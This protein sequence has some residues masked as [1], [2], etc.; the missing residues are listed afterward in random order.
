VAAAS[1]TQGFL[2]GMRGVAFYL[3]V[4]GFMTIG[5]FAVVIVL[6]GQGLISDELEDLNGLYQRSPASAV[7][8]LIFML[9]LAGIPP[10]AGFVGKYYILL[11]LIQTGHTRL[12]LFGA[13]YIVPA[14]YYYFRIVV[15]AWLREPGSAP[16]PVVTLGQKVALATLGAVTVAAGIYPEPFIRL[17]NYSLFFPTGFSGH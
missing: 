1:D 13:L 2:T 10:L 15:H 16:V 5:A 17:A 7:M 12:A 11:A 8:L 9:S 14:L 3:F 6:Q 4:Y